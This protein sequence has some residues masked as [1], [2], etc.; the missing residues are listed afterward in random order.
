[1]TLVSFWPKHT[2]Y[3]PHIPTSQAHHSTFHN[4]ASPS[5]G[6]GVIHCIVFIAFHISHLHIV[7]IIRQQA[8][9]LPLGWLLQPT[10][11]VVVTI[12]GKVNY[13]MFSHSW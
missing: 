10:N 3:P 11:N 8:I 4:T 13:A 6:P 5:Q 1:M 12:R 7:I 9:F 2:I